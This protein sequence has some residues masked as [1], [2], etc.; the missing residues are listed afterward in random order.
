M[1]Y[2]FLLLLTLGLYS[3]SNKINQYIFK[4]NGNI[5]INTFIFSFFFGLI[6][7]INSYLFILNING[8]YFA[9][10]FFA[11]IIIYSL[12]QIKEIYNY[13]KIFK[14]NY[15]SNNKIILAIFL[16]YFFT[17]LL[18]VA[19]E[20]S[21]RYHLEIGKK[22]N[23]GTFYNNTW[24]DYIAL[25][26][27][28]F[29]NSFALHINFEHIS[30]YSNFVALSFAIVSNIYILKKYKKGSGISSAIIL[31][32][33]PYLI[34]LI[35]SQKFYFFPCFIVSYSIAYLYLEK[36]IN[37]ITIYLILLLNIFCV[38]IKPTF[39]PYL[40]L[41]GIWLF[42]INKGYK[43]KIFYLLGAIVLLIIFYFPIFIIKQ[44]IYNDPFLPYIS[45]NSQNFAWLSDYNFYLKTW[46]MDIT[47]TINNLFLKYLL[48]PIKL[49][50]P[51]SFSDIFKSLGLGL[52]FLF[53]FNY[54]KN[55]NLLL[56]L[57]F[58]IFAVILLNN[59]QTRWFLPLLIFISIFA[60]IDKL[61]IL[62]KT[63]F[64]QLIAVSCIIVPMSLA[65][66]A[67]NIGLLDKKVILDKIFQSHK[68]IEHINNKHRNE[69]IF[70]KIN[71]YYYFDNVVPVYYPKI[72]KKFDKNYYKNNEKTTKLILWPIGPDDSY[73]AIKFV[74]ENLS[75][76]KIKEIDEFSVGV[77]R[78][79]LN[80]KNKTKVILYK[81][82][83]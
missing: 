19:D 38:I 48:I 39:A 43:N 60:K 76:N 36:K 5:I 10:L 56:L 63:T 15:I 81:L 32:S 64:L 20:D 70:S 29:I 52:L 54:R 80:Q 13:F 11:I 46:N 9:Y 49:V 3:A 78:N 24:F 37:T 1:I 45:L 35:P 31:L 18:P 74:S 33:C 66:L 2:I 8:K 25:G 67:T 55:K 61:I 21:L 73:D 6:Y 4:E 41:V 57:L 75:C 53:S 68:L 12:L 27:H 77:E 44:K 7:I 34:A 30:S 14:L 83:C 26:A 82:D 79:F 72:V 71:Y 28:E 50:L 17:I 65:T 42:I 58:F 51:L 22:I 62:K 69:K 16:F 40:I 47:D 23:N 59:Y